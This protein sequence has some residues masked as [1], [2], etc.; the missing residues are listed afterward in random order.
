MT[1]PSTRS[2]GDAS[3]IVTEI[4]SQSRWTSDFGEVWAYRELLYFLIWK[5]L[6]VRYKQSALGAA[7]AIIQPV[8]AVAVFTIVFGRFAKIPSDNVAYAPFFAAISFTIS[9]YVST[10]S[11]MLSALA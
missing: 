11:A 3:E 7:Y 2:H 9:R 8:F 1:A 4:R 5:D 10:W 6:K